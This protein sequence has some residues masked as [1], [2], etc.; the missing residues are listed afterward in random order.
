MC[1]SVYWWRCVSYSYRR[2]GSCFTQHKR[3]SYR[4][5]HSLHGARN[6]RLQ[7]VQRKN[8]HVR[9]W[10]VS[11][12]NPN[13]ENALLGMPIHKRTHRQDP[14]GLHLC[15][16]SLLGRSPCRAL[17]NHRPRLQAAHRAAAGAARDAPDGRRSAGGLV[18]AAGRRR[19]LAVAARVR[20]GVSPGGELD[21]CAVPSR[22]ERGSTGT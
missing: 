2:L 16:N 18:S 21:P 11:A 7:R 9:L 17:R 1:K 14:F 20:G 4:W 3:E 10:H 8:G 15:A 22:M 12:R 6:H 19:G 5:H 13:K